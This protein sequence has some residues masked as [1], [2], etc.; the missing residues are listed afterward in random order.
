MNEI[1]ILNKDGQLTVSSVQVANDF[2]K[3]HD[4]LVSEIERMYMD[5]NLTA[6]N[7]GVKNFFIESSYINERGRSYKCYELTRDGFSLLVMGFTGKKAL[8]W[9]LK[10]IEAFNLMEQ[11]LRIGCAWLTPDFIRETIADVMKEYLPKPNMKKINVWKAQVVKPIINNLHN[12]AGTPIENIYKTIY[13]V[14]EKAHGFNQCYAITSYCDKYNLETCSVIDAIADN[15]EYQEQFIKSAKRVE[16]VVTESRRMK[17][18]YGISNDEEV[19]EDEVLA[20]KGIKEN[21]FDAYFEV[22][23]PLA[24]RYNDKSMYYVATLRKVYKRMKSVQSWKILKTRRNCNTIKEVIERDPK[25]IKLYNNT[26]AE[27]ITEFDN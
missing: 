20:E 23:E 27:M 15:I 4:K 17:L 16:D 18:Q 1:T 24:E 11:N 22:V 26:I 19:D 3:R 6:Q 21:R 5:L 9:K 2:G 13:F 10:Y 12:I 7:G 25:L 14:M 8:E